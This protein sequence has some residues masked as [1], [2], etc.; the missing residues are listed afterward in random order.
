MLLGQLGTCMYVHINDW[1]NKTISFQIILLFRPRSIFLWRFP[2]I[3]R[4]ETRRQGESLQIRVKYLVNWSKTTISRLSQW[5]T[6]K[7]LSLESVRTI[8]QTQGKT[9]FYRSMEDLYVSTTIAQHAKILPNI[10][11]ILASKIALW[12][13]VSLS[14]CVDWTQLLHYQIVS[15]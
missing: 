7:L 5:R 6:K 3:E 15:L 9:I 2:V 12:A 13:R 4:R 1:F 14:L 10:T 8:Y 11:Y